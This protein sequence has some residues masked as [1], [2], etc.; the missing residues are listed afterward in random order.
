[1]PFPNHLLHNNISNTNNQQG[2]GHMNFFSKDLIITIGGIISA[3]LVPAVWLMS[4][5]TFAEVADKKAGLE[6]IIVTAERRETSL[7][8]TPVTISA[9]TEESLERFQAVEAT[10]LQNYVPN[11]TMVQGIA[12]PGKVD[13]YMR[14]A[15]D[16]VGAV[17]LSE[18]GV[19][20]YIDDVYISRL[21]VANIELLELER[22]E[23]L[24]GPQGTL[25]GRNA[26][27][28]VIKYITKKPDGTQSGNLAAG[29]G[30]FGSF[31]VRGH[32]QSSLVEDVIGA[33]VTASYRESGDWYSNITLNEERGNRE[34][35]AINSKLALLAEGPLSGTLSLS[36]AEEN[37]D[38]GEF[39]ARDPDTL[40][41][42]T[43]D[44]RDV[45]SPLDAFGENEQLR[46]T[47]DFSYDFGNELNLRS[48]TSFQ[49]ISEASSFDLTGQGL[50][51]RVLA[52]DVEVMTQEIQL[53][54]SASGGNLDWLAGVFLFSEDGYQ[55]IDDTIF[56][57][58]RP[59]T[60]IDVETDSFAVY[61][62]GTYHFSEKLSFT[63]GLR[64]SDDKKDLTGVHRGVPGSA[65]NSSDDVTMRLVLDYQWTEDVFTFF[66]I[67]RGYKAGSF[68]ALATS[69]EDFTNGFDPETV[70]AYEFGVKADLLDNR[71]RTNVNVFFN[72]FSD[73]QG[74]NT[75]ASG[76]TTVNNVADADVYGIELE[77]TYIV[78]DQLE[79]FGSAAFQGDEYNDI[80]PTSGIDPSFKINR[81]SDRFGSLGFEY[82]FISGASGGQFGLNGNLSYRSE[83][84]NDIINA[85]IVRTDGYS[86][87]NLGAFYESAQGEW[88]I[89]LTGKNVLDE[90]VYLKGL[91]LI[92]TTGVPNP[93]PVWTL[94]VR[95]N[96]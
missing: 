66:N 17:I 23:V 8:S 74:L 41:S 72:D 91:P 22:V 51:N 39:V 1:M 33:S 7:Q 28:G 80:D 38:G 10:E 76:I 19:G 13:L 42:I 62:E 60:I 35:L 81:A 46:V 25:Y 96:F 58:V 21:S 79:M 36:Y 34:V 11:L 50:F 90:E 45:Q 30:S 15:G 68:N 37:N 87:L 64:Y 61:G 6:E 47:L 73:L 93:P 94:G 4:A 65:V 2:E 86:L 71:L 56:F 63:A 24:R 59:S 3:T 27:G 67:S 77:F 84:Y 48:I 82:L 89:S 44:F 78:N 5:V 49:D 85:P 88:K 75:T 92:R 95:R 18:S 52:S 14:G 32:F 43:G 9:F 57:G 55:T 83:Y 26:M 31:N 29:Y 16:Q 40:N 70:W 20:V 54:G 53:R 69:V 12:A